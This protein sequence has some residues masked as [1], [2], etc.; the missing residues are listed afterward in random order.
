MT[1][2][3]IENFFKELTLKYGQTWHPD[4]NFEN[5]AEEVMMDKCFE[6]CNENNIDIYELGFKIINHDTHKN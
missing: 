5:K 6:H 2:Q 3:D 4:D 1:T